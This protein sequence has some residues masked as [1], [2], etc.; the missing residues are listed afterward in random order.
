VFKMNPLFFIILLKFLIHFK[1]LMT[2]ITGD[3]MWLSRTHR[4]FLA[5]MMSG[6]A[7]FLVL[8]SVMCA[9]AQDFFPLFDDDEPRRTIVRE[10]K[11]RSQPQPHLR[12]ERNNERVEHSEESR[13]HA[14]ASRPAPKEVKSTQIVK[15]ELPLFAIVSVADQHISIYN[16]NGLVARSMVS[17]GIEGHP[18]PK[19]IFT[20]L[21][22]ERFHQSNIYSGAPMPFM[23]RITWSGIAMHTGVVPGHPAS[24]GCIRLPADF[25]SRLWGMTRIGE[26]IV[27]SPSEVTPEEFSHPLLFTPKLQAFNDL[28]KESTTGAL[29]QGSEEASQ[30]KLINPLQVAERL[31]NKAIKDAAIA[32][33]VLKE[34]TSQMALKQQES[35]NSARD[36]KIAQ[37]GF[38]L[39]QTKVIAATKFYEESSVKSALSQEEVSKARHELKDA[40]LNHAILAKADRLEKILQ[41]NVDV[42]DGALASKTRSELSLMDFKQRLEIAEKTAAAASA[43]IAGMA[44]LVME[45][46]ELAN[47][48][49]TA[50]KLARQRTAPVSIMV[51]K[52]DQK[53]YVRQ[54]LVPVFDAPISVRDPQSPLGEHLYIATA[55]NDDGL[56][57]KWSAISLPEQ[58]I[59]DHNGR[60]KNSATMLESSNSDQLFAKTASN[61]SEALERIELAQDVR[62]RIAERLWT[63]SSLI[64]S[65][66]SP[67][68]ETGNDGT[69]L[70]VKI[71]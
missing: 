31:K 56:S 30:T 43:E 55:A 51:S 37:A 20:I 21:G 3:L 44:K 36:L 6:C 63:G 29:T 1:K 41:K 64:I 17:T 68:S 39:A 70:T 50:E 42:R 9:Q 15:R 16:H 67:S 53:I 26:R 69:D 19:G 60:K 59:D 35:T 54:G 10:P 71:R 45:K 4:N 25:A 66:Q 14:V 40:A 22:R 46:T 11:T 38:Q 33:K 49:G 47:M 48:A 8:A 13:P 7:S 18:T 58:P 5:F 32:A 34:V 65:D 27:I 57:L 23:Q 62:E 61:A 52:K 28:V 2:H 24:H 12:S